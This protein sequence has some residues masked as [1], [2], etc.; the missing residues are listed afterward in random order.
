MLPTQILNSLITCSYS[1]EQIGKHI[2]YTE[3]RVGDVDISGI[4][5]LGNRICANSLCNN[6]GV[7]TA[8]AAQTDDCSGGPLRG[9]YVT[10]QRYGIEPSGDYGDLR[11]AEIN[12]EFYL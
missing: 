11:L 9:R 7:G 4:I 10:L 5:P 1:N 6:T 2:L 3:V 12:I 8:V